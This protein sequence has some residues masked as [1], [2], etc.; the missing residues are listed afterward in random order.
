MRA[1]SSRQ[2]WRCRCC[3]A[4]RYWTQLEGCQGRSTICGGTYAFVDISNLH[5]PCCEQDLAAP[6]SRCASLGCRLHQV[7]GTDA[8]AALLVEVHDHA[9]RAAH[10]RHRRRAMAPVRTL[11]QLLGERAIAPATFSHAVHMLLQLMMMRCA[12]HLSTQ[13]LPMTAPADNL[14]QIQLLCSPT[15]TSAPASFLEI[16]VRADNARYF[17]AECLKHSCAGFMALVDY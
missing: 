12:E 3:Q 14:Q 10:P 2:S 7:L 6:N 16:E 13:S 9:L 5:S 8:V 1:A 11:L 17:S 15:W 4:Q